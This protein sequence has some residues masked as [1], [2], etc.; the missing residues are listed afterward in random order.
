MVFLYA[1]S[2]IPRSIG[3]S[4][5]NTSAAAQARL[6]NIRMSANPARIIVVAL[7]ALTW[8]AIIALVLPK[9]GNGSTVDAGIAAFA[10]VWNVLGLCFIR[11]T[12]SSAG[13]E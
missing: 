2:Q 4:S 13:P 3:G 6:V 5:P 12:G 10:A 7:S 8:L 9:L 11:L 1:R